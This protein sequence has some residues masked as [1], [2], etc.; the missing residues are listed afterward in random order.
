MIPIAQTLELALQ[1]Q[2]AGNP[3]QAEILYRQ[4]LEVDPGLAH[5]HNNLG[6]ALKKQG[7]LDRAV[8][9]YERALMLRPSYPLAHHNLGIALMELDRLEEAEDSLR[10][11]IRLKPDYAEACTH[12]GIVLLKRGKAPEATAYCEE[13]LRLRPDYP[14]GRRNM[15]MLRLMLGDLE[16]G[17]PEYESRWECGGIDPPAVPGPWWDGSPLSGRTILLFAEQGIGDTLQF[18][19]FAPL[20]GA[21][22]G[23]V[24]LL[25]APALVKLLTSCEY[26]ERVFPNDSQIPPF[27]VHAPLMSLP[28][29]LKTSLATLP[30]DVPYIHVSDESRQY[31]QR[32]LAGISAFKIG[33]SWQGNSKNPIDRRRSIALEEFA[34]LANVPGVVLFSLQKGEGTEQLERV[35]FAVTDRCGALD[36]ADTA[37]VIQNLDLV[38]SI[39]SAL[40][41]LAGALAVPVWV[42]LSPWSDFRWLLEREDSPWY[43]TA[44]LFREERAGGWQPV[45]ERMAA[46]LRKIVA[47]NRT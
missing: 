29:V 15:G 30:A 42:A 17:W 7:Q 6:I 10:A 24:S 11:A 5:V 37:A 35:A 34:P 19:R 39:D 4:V 33:I 41:H 12:L 40:A 3:R 25:C 16:R 47:A 8:A 44:R 18:V 2:R 14:E 23:R 26:F 46:E 9:S 21:R 45:F 20:V 36:L 13:A 27:D 31:W 38:I 1:H 28:A 22:G 32:E 43:P